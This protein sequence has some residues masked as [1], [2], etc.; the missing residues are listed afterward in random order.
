MQIHV[1][2][3]R[4]SPDHRTVSVIKGLSLYEFTLWGGDLESVAPTRESPYYRGFFKRKYMRI[5]SG[6]WK[7]S[8]NIEVSVLERCSYRKVR[9]YLLTNVKRRETA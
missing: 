5:L 7:L 3:I 6:H 8:C 2:G 1:I 9:L 4:D